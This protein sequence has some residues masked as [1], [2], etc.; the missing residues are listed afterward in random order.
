MSID[1][2]NTL[3]GNRYQ[4]LDRIGAGG[5]GIVYRAVDRLN[6]DI[7]AL[8]MV[9]VPGE[10]LE[11]ASKF[12]GGDF[13][14]ALAQEFRTLATV[15]HPYIIS[16]LDYGFHAEEGDDRRQPYFTMELLEDA[17]P[18]TDAVADSSLD[19]K[20]V[21]VSQMVQ[22]LAY[23]HR[24]GIIHRDMKPDN[25]IVIEGEEGE[26]EVRVLDFGLAMARG[27]GLEEQAGTLAYMAP[28][29]LQGELATEMSDL[30]AVGIMAYELIADKH[31]FATENIG[32][33]INNMV[34]GTPDL[35]VLNVTAEMR[36]LLAQLLEKNPLERL[37]SAQTV[38]KLLADATGKEVQPETETIRESFLQAARFVGREREL[39]LLSAALMRVVGIKPG[40]APL[41]LM[42]EE[43]EYT[44]QPIGSVWLVGGESG[45][46]KSRLLEEL[47]TQSLVEGALVLRGQAVQDTSIPYLSWQNVLQQLCLQITLS[48]LEISTLKS[49]VPDIDKLLNVPVDS[50]METTEQMVNQTLLLKTIELIF[51][52]QDRPV[53]VILENLHWA[54]EDGFNLLKRL[55]RIIASMRLMIVASY[56]SDEAPNLPDRL[57]TAELIELDRLPRET[58]AA[59]SESMLG[60]AGRSELVVDMLE[61]ETEGNVFFI[62]EAVRALAEESGE[63]AQVGRKTLPPK[64]FAEGMKSVVR[65]RLEGVQEEARPLLY[66]AAAMGREL[67]LDVLQ[68]IKSPMD[69]G[70]WL[71]VCEMAILL[72][73]R[74]GKWQFVHDKLREG[75][76]EE[77]ALAAYQAVH[78]EAAEKI[79]ELHPDDP[80]QE[81][82]LARLWCGV[83]DYARELP[84]IMSAAR[85]LVRKEEYT[86][87]L[88]LYERAMEL[89]QGTGGKSEHTA[90]VNAGIGELY[91]Q[92]GRFGQAEPFLLEGLAVAE[93]N[94][95]LAQKAAVLRLL[96][97]TKKRVGDDP[98][99]VL[100]YW[101]QNLEIQQGLDDR[102][103]MALAHNDLGNIQ[104]ELDAYIEALTN[105]LQSISLANELNDGSLVARNLMD[106]GHMEYRRGNY[107]GAQA[108]YEQSLTRYATLGENAAV[109]E[110]FMGMARVALGIDEYEA[111]NT[112]VEHGVVLA[113]SLESARFQVAALELKARI[114]AGQRDSPERAVELLTFTA[115][116]PD[117]SDVGEEQRVAL[118]DGLR[119]RMA[120]ETYDEAVRR[121]NNR[122]LDD[123]VGEL[124][125]PP[126]ASD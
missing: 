107:A 115:N 52:R 87:A 67:D 114:L 74:E 100:D 112:Y 91:M 64:I 3:I 85:R 61:R 28:E 21:L 69:F 76:L 80:E 77:L 40:T 120:A 57:P 23:L 70:D 2:I 38:I 95:L 88:E 92:M 126:P 4:I 82:R 49:I 62:V 119:G 104:T 58:I 9:T 12:E 32:E 24:R 31:P 89:V 53:V 116:H 101:R 103:A 124:L 33:L 1:S 59:L 36:D 35:D 72:E 125:A 26:L 117:H 45:V 93:K 56:R 94:D 22:A 14:I 66:A 15:R 18:I 83:G 110:A 48:P 75:L 54:Q 123:I 60:E 47:R 121:G 42:V 39:E 102:A 73:V 71:F 13:N 19:Q 11:F 55:T 118:L 109:V 8:K 111:A 17:R 98:Q 106:I 5:M 99:E 27:Q 96:G 25:V 30:F 90:M 34:F 6:D 16:V 105:F 65:R 79:E 43:T 37:D 7:I 97:E 29:L 10:H 86:R 51:R 63:L 46:G 20:I 44:G 78:R 122:R 41:N 84:Y 113:Q 50:K 108:N 68:A 81:V